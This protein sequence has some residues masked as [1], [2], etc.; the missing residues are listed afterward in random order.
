MWILTLNMWTLTLNVSTLTLNMWTPTLNQNMWLALMEGV[1]QYHLLLAA[2][3][4]F[5]AFIRVEIGE[6]PN[7][8]PVLLHAR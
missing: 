7:A 2:L 3:P 5:L 8:G 1:G 4:P 6:G